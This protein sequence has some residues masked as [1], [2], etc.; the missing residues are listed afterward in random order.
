LDHPEIIAYASQYVDDNS[1]EQFL[2]EETGAGYPERLKA[3]DGYYYP[4]MTQ[5]RSPE[6]MTLFVQKYVF[7]P[8]HFLP[9]DGLVVIEG[10]RNPFAVTSNSERGESHLLR[11]LDG[12][13]P[14]QIG[15]ALHT[16][17][18]SW[19][20]QNFTG[21]R[22]DWN[23]FD[24]GDDLPK[25]IVP[26]IGHGDAG[27]APDIISESWVDPRFGNGRIDNR[28]RAFEA[29]REIFVHF[30]RRSHKGPSWRD[31]EDDFRTI[32][33]A[34]DSKGRENRVKDF[35]RDHRNGPLPEY[36]RKS[37][38]DEAIDRSGGE[39]VLKPDFRTTHW[40]HFQQAA[41][42]HLAR[43]IDLIKEL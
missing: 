6:A 30:Q 29:A 27:K 22:E 26:K 16:F 36:S 35:V 12:G 7:I 5:C 11:A 21:L 17:G 15:I 33:K 23:S 24:P 43:V 40:Y 10:K 37:W 34:P 42:V 1:D 25:S 18:D 38:V 14:Y 19:S 9:G 13:N 20:H 28:E 32:M 2:G 39:R 8:F 4:Q 31:V 41:K 3:K